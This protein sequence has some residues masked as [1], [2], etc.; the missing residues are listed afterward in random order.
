MNRTTHKHI[1][2]FMIMLTS[3]FDGIKWTIPTIDSYARCI[4]MMATELGVSQ[5]ANCSYSIR[6]VT[7]GMMWIHCTGQLCSRYTPFAQ[8]TRWRT[9]QEICI[10]GVGA[11]VEQLE[12]VLDRQGH[13]GSGAIRVCSC[14]VRSIEEDKNTH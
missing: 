4:C 13:R 6:S 5:S 12:D 14:D 11:V 3:R 10:E 9:Y 1:I 7:W 8:L 2:E